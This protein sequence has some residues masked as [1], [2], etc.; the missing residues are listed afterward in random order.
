MAQ[1]LASLNVTDVQLDYELPVQI[2]FIL[3]GG[4]GTVTNA[5]VILTIAKTKELH[6]KSQYAICC[7]A[8]TEFMLALSTFSYGVRGWFYY[9]LGI[10]SISQYDCMLMNLGPYIFGSVTIL[11]TM[12]LGIDRLLA[13]KFPIF[14]KQVNTFRYLIVFNLGTVLYGL[15]QL[16]ESFVLTAPYANGTV[17]VCEYKTAYTPFHLMIANNGGAVVSLFTIIVYVAALATVGYRYWGTKWLNEAQRSAWARKVQ[18]SAFKTIMILGAIYFC[19]WAMVIIFQIASMFMAPQA[20][21][22]LTLY[23]ALLLNVNGITHLFVYL[24]LNQK[25]KGGFQDIFM[26]KKNVVVSMVSRSD[27]KSVTRNTGL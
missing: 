23:G 6:N 18:F 9:V 14:Y 8:F 16:V 2:C 4:A 13:S 20:G 1:N 15:L 21:Y 3:L 25:F 7:H 22:L 10:P 12:Q 5:L 17:E 11:A 24:I 26:R 19:C 27:N